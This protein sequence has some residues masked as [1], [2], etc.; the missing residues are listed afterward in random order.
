MRQFGNRDHDWVVFLGD[1]HRIADVVEVAVGAEHDV[2]LLDMLFSFSG[3]MGLPMTQGS[4]MNGL[5]RRSFDAKGS[6]AQPGEF[7]SVQIHS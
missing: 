4:T 2:H 3:H 7:D 6:V 1:F 5:S